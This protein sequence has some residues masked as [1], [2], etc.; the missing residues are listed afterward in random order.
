M[1][2]RAILI[3]VIVIVILYLIIKYFMGHSNLTHLS[4]AKTKQIISPNNLDSSNAQGSNFTYSV[5]FYVSNWNYRY[6]E[7]KVILGRLNKEDE[8]SPSISLGAM[9]N[10]LNITVTTYPTSNSKQQGNQHTCNVQNVPLQKWVNLIVSLYGRS[11]DVYIDGKLVRTCVLPGVAKVDYNAPVLV[12]PSDGFAGFTSNI[13]YW[14]S[15]TNPQEAWNIY[16]N[17]Y[18]GS[19]LGNIFNKYRV[20]IT[21]LEDN[22]PEGSFEI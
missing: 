10:D 11:M 6:G 17:G 15:P 9:S 5:W 7:P 18:G 13:Q 4:D 14:G 12:T 16:K 19:A 8:P 3:A 1:N 21:F 22:Q 2:L 20:K